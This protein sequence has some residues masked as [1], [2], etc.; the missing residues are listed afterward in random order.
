VAV[1]WFWYLGTLVPVVGIVQ[2]GEQSHADRYTY[3]TV[4]GLTI[5][6]V[7]TTASVVS[8]RPASR[9]V[10][11][12]GFMLWLGVLAVL[13]HRQIGVWRDSVTLWTHGTTV[14]ANSFVGHNNLG[15]AL[16]RLPSR[17]AEAAAHFRRV[18]E[19]RPDDALGLGN[20]GV[21]LIR[22]GDLVQAKQYLRRAVQRDPTHTPSFIHLGNLYA[23]E[24][25]LDDALLVYRE[26]LKR[27]PDFG[28]GHYN[29]AVT[30]AQMGDLP[31]A[32]RH[33]ERALAIRRDDVEARRG[34]G[35]ALL[36]T[37]RTGEGVAALREAL[38][39]RPDDPET[40][41]RLAWV[42]ATLPGSSPW[43]IGEAVRLAEKVRESAG[44]VAPRPDDP[45]LPGLGGPDGLLG[46][47]EAGRDAARLDTL[48]AALA[49]AGRF[50]EAVG[51]ATVAESHARAAGL[52]T[53]A[54]AIAERIDL[55]RSGRAFVQS[56]RS[57]PA[58]TAPGR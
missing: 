18:L 46:T 37:G 35:V 40:Q 10:V 25:R 27:N 23:R 17:D 7:Y 31:G 50:E 42:L 57:T 54:K 4:I 52:Q 30:L 49:R 14:V 8:G 6:G 26:G 51:A 29:V 12:K 2:V 28:N 38:A 20:Y 24:G 1:G 22:A 45:R 15:E 21:A 19:I 36:M 3:L 55:Y 9:A 32:I 47:T 16:M 41:D 11:G 58:A 33:F 39:A 5:A 43:E 48:A 56:A 13:S 44:P 34:L 53:L